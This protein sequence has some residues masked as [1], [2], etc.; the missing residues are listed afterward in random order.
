MT[1]E[2]RGSEPSRFSA[3]VGL[4]GRV[5]RAGYA[6]ILALV[7]A[8]WMHLG[9]PDGLREVF[10]FLIGDRSFVLMITVAFALG[11]LG[12]IRQSAQPRWLDVRPWVGQV[13]VGVLIAVL[14]IGIYLTRPS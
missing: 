9:S 1:T 11:W 14:M 2:I 10:G 5:F 8:G 7:A 12:T 6:W 4:L 13:L 3:V